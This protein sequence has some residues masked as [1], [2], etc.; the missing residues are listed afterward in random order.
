MRVPHQTR[1]VDATNG[2]PRQCDIRRHHEAVSIRRVRFPPRLRGREVERV[3]TRRRGTT[4][5]R[6]RAVQGVFFRVAQ[7][8]GASG[9]KRFSPAGSNSRPK[10][11]YSRMGSGTAGTDNS[12]AVVAESGFRISSQF[13]EA[14]HTVFSPA[15]AEFPGPAVRTDCRCNSGPSGRDRA[16]LP[17][18]D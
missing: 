3:S 8:I 12:A 16:V 4:T 11:T 14:G 1:G 9:G 6:V 7:V 5:I 10:D 2:G 17:V 18:R 15:Q 13:P